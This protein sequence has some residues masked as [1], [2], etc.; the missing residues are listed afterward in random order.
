MH[1]I[2]TNINVLQGI[3]IKTNFEMSFPFCFIVSS[4]VII[5]TE[6]LFLT[7]V[8]SITSSNLSLVKI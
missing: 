8:S 4:S 5:L 1:I 6:I 2:I 3:P 7:N